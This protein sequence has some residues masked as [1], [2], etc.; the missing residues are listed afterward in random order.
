MTKSSRRSAPVGVPPNS[1]AVHISGFKEMLT[2]DINT[3][4]QVCAPCWNTTR[5]LCRPRS[6]HEDDL[7]RGLP[8]CEHLVRPPRLRERQF[9]VDL[10]LQLAPADHLEDRAGAREQLV[11]RS[12][13]A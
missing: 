10:H 2:V 7:P 8:R 5:T 12:D 4:P 6:R 9:R 3:S 1:M 11:A 13:V